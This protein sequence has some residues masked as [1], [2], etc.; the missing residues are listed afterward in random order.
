DLYPPGG[1]GAGMRGERRRQ[2]GMLTL[3]SPERLVPRDHPIRRIKA[4]ADAELVRL[5]AV[6]D[7]MYAQRGRPSIPPEVLKGAVPDRALQCAERAPVLRAARVQFAL[8]V[9]P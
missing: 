9:L 7:R 1:K 4:L 5:S 3:I 6:F 8:P 2:V